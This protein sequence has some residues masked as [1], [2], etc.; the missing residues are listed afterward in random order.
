MGGW[1]PKGEARGECASVLPERD[2][3]ANET[4]AHQSKAF[5]GTRLRTKRFF[6]GR[7][8]RRHQNRR[9]VAWRSQNA[10]KRR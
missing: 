3:N 10:Q 1:T 4:L 7:I 9:L 5:R 8:G 2:Q 6:K